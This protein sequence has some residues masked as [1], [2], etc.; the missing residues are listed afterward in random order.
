[1]AVKVIFAVYGGLRDGNPDK[2]EAKDVTQ[3]LQTA[4]NNSVG[5]TVKIDNKTMGG[6]PARRV[7]K[8]FGAIVE[9]NGVKRAFACQE[10][11]TIDFTT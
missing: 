10:N 3:A 6:D 7:K 9:V 5:E 2:T 11:E 1:M 4:I 8:Q